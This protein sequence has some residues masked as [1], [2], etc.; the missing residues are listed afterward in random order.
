MPPHIALFQSYEISCFPWSVLCLP[1]KLWYVSLLYT[2]HI[3][4]VTA[5]P[6]LCP[7]KWPTST[8]YPMFLTIHSFQSCDIYLATLHWLPVHI[9]HHAFAYA[10]AH[11]YTHTN[12]Y[13]DT[14][15]HPFMTW[16]KFIATP[17]TMPTPIHAPNPT[18]TPIVSP[19]SPFH[20]HEWY[21]YLAIL[22]CPQL[23]LRL[24]LH[25]R[26]YLHPRQHI[27]PFPPQHPILYL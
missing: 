1:L 10:N 25:P 16:S 19:I 14:Q 3:S 18:C 7:R 11:T 6:N 15:T 8:S 2:G 5:P 4:S 13:A 12:V 27:R 26:L 17:A 23:A 21:C 9:H 22:T 20:S 24:H